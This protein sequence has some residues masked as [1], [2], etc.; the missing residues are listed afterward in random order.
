M[1]V[2]RA[3]MWN[4]KKF[5]DDPNRASRI[6]VRPFLQHVWH[7]FSRSDLRACTWSQVGVTN[8][9]KALAVAW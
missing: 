3:Q 9:Q 8:P 2:R 1:Q 6:M 4:Y 7:A 5:Y